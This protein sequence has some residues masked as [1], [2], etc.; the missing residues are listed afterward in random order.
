M[1]KQLHVDLLCYL[2]EQSK[3]DPWA[4]ELFNELM[5]ATVIYTTVCPTTKP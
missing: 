3:I 1:N 2:R 4:K 5:D